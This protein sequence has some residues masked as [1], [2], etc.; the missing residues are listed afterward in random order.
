[1]DLSTGPYSLVKDYVLE[2][3][4]SQGKGGHDDTNRI[5]R[6]MNID[7]KRSIKRNTG[8]QNMDTTPYIVAYLAHNSDK[9]D[10]GKILTPEHI[11]DIVQSYNHGVDIVQSY[12]HGE[13]Y[14]LQN[15]KDIDAD[16]FDDILKNIGA[17]SYKNVRDALNSD[18]APGSGFYGPEDVKSILQELNDEIKKLDVKNTRPYLKAY[19]AHNSE[20]IDEDK[21]LTAGKIIEIV[22]NNI[23]GGRRKS[24]SRKQKRNVNKRNNRSRTQKRNVNKR[25]NNT[26]VGGMF[27]RF[28]LSSSEKLDKIKGFYTKYGHELPEDCCDEDVLESIIQKCKQKL[29]D[30]FNPRGYSEEAGRKVLA[31]IKNGKRG[32]YF[33][34]DIMNDTLD[35]LDMIDHTDEFDFPARDYKSIPEVN[36]PFD[37]YKMLPIAAVCAD[38]GGGL[39]SDMI[40]VNYKEWK[41]G[42][43][44]KD[45]IKTGTSVYK[46]VVSDIKKTYEEYILLMKMLNSEERNFVNN[47]LKL[48]HNIASVTLEENLGMSSSGFDI[49]S[50]SKYEPKL[51][52][53]PVELRTKSSPGNKTE[54]YEFNDGKS[55]KFWNI[56]YNTGGEYTVNYGKIGSDGRTT[57]KKDTKENIQKLIDSKVKKGYKKVTSSP[58][59]LVAKKSSSSKK[60]AKKSPA[61]KPEKS[62]CKKPRG[63]PRKNKR[64]DC[65]KGQW[66]DL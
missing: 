26:K 56:T 3:K 57:T 8:N 12:N 30:D 13:L 4:V 37:Y 53:L 18:G 65:D 59:K 55:H 2:G 6:E 25:R 43:N 29:I 51:P 24:K 61:K 66:V 36:N 54:K 31:E 32:Y 63:R 14:N 16:T 38:N 21:G 47:L 19:L 64:W 50:P 10:D 17:N 34:K 39:P 40:F 41:E 27:S 9:L 11:I 58:A 35:E 60:T 46:E 48:S 23:S 33:V 44:D 20:K 22:D 5:L 7:I 28:G 49:D 45:D 42:E 1:M 15:N 52:A 62:S